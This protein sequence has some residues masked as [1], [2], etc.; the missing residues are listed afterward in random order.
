MSLF[1][2]LNLGKKLAVG[3]GLILVLMIVVSAVAYKGIKS[4]IYTTGWVEHTHEVIR[5]GENVSVS[6]VD[7]ETGLRGFMVTGD[8]NYLEPYHNGNKNFDKLMTLK[9][10]AYFRSN[11]KDYSELGYRYKWSP[12][13]PAVKFTIVS[14]PN[15][16]FRRGIFI[17]G[18]EEFYLKGALILY[19]EQNGIK[20]YK[21]WTFKKLY[22]TCYSF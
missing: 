6:M 8:E 10:N 4:L 16:K 2:N 3:Y 9:G 21:S 20:G 18:R 14:A 15:S 5:V 17:H 22:D 12:F 13:I 11:C 19:L 1:G 7:M